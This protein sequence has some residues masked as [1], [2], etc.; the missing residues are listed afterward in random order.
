MLGPGNTEAARESLAAWPGNLQVGGGITDK[1]AAEW[2]DAG[3][4]KV[5]FSFQFFP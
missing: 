5:C 3:A 1:N 4:S 2:I